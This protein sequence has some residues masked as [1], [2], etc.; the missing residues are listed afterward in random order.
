MTSLIE[1]QGKDIEELKLQFS[2]MRDTI[3]ELQQIILDLQK[4]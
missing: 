3:S 4:T 2:G 1:N